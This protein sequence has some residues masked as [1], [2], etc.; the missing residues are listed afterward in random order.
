MLVHNQNLGGYL[1]Y[2]YKKKRPL[3]KKSLEHD[4]N[5]SVAQVPWP[6][7]R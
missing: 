5:Q 2:S 4:M 7:R 6:Q 3:Y 1:S